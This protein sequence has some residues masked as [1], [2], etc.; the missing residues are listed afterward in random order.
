MY[1][2][3]SVV[4]SS[5]Q[6]TSNIDCNRLVVQDYKDFVSNIDAHFV[7]GESLLIDFVYFIHPVCVE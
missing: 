1:L 5:F 6:M 4:Q 3:F 7:S 2:S